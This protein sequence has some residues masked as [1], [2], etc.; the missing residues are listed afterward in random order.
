MPFTVGGQV[1]AADAVARYKAAAPTAGA[2]WAKK[3]LMPRRNPIQAAKDASARWLGNINAAG[4]AGFIAGLDRVDQNKMADTI[5]NQGPALYNAG[6]TAKA[7]KFEAAM[8]KLMP[9]IRSVQSSLPAR[10]DIEANI[11]RSAAM[12]RGLHAHKGEARA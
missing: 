8:T 12:N 11:A 6:V 10:G 2:Q 3:T 7:Y 4:E 9:I 1:T 5:Q